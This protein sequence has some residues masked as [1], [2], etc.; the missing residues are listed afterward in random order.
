MP[1]VLDN[2]VDIA[3]PTEEVFDYLS[4]LRNER[5][6]NPKMKSVELLTE[7]PI[8]VGSRYQ[9]R[10]AGSPN[11]MVEYLRFDRPHEWAS[12]GTS[13]Q[14]T[15]NFRARVSPRAAGSHLAV[16]M[17]LVPHGVNRLLL[18]ILRRLMQRQ[19]LDNMRYIKNAL[20]R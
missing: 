20:E 7:G 11:N 2:G 5:E 17:E 16:R 3:R 18:P 1:A 8:R 6:W 13:T 12:T 19:E 14:M 9:A 4:D 10:W 15:I